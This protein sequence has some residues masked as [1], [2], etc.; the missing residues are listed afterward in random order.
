MPRRTPPDRLPALIQAATQIFIS[1]GYRRT[2]MEDVA[3][4]VGIAKAT[5]YLSFES[6]EALFDAVL[7][8]A[9][10]PVPRQLPHR[11][12]RTPSP[13]ATLDEVTRRLSEESA[14]PQLAAALGRGRVVNVRAELEGILGEIYDAMA[15]NRTGITLLDRCAH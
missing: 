3:H 9:D 15:R 1:Q 12:V 14:R 8:S 11:P 7:R 13:Q 5:L 10:R 2:Q 4:A 6:K